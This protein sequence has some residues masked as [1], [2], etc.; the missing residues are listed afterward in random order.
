MCLWRE[1][2]GAPLWFRLGIGLAQLGFAELQLVE[3]KNPEADIF[4]RKKDP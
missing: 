3:N 2:G 1:G 4:L